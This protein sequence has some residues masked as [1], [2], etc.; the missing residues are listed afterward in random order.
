MHLPCLIV[1]LNDNRIKIC[2]KMSQLYLFSK[3]IKRI[4]SCFES[5]AFFLGKYLGGACNKQFASS[6]SSSSSK[7]TCT[8]DYHIFSKMPFGGL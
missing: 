8:T 6:S 7:T 4:N 3:I 5:F 2:C 1:Y